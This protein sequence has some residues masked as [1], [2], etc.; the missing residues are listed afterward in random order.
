VAAQPGAETSP[1]RLAGVGGRPETHRPVSRLVFLALMD[2]FVMDVYGIAEDAEREA[3]AWLAAEARARKV[4]GAIVVPNLDGISQL[5]GAL[6]RDQAHL[7]KKNRYLDQDGARIEVYTDQNRPG[8]FKGPVFVP[9]ANE[10]SVERVEEMRPVAI[11]AIPW[12]EDDLSD[13]KRAHDPVDLRTGVRAGAQPA[14]L[15]PLVRAALISLTAPEPHSSGIHHPSDKAR[16]TRTFRALYLCGEPLDETEIRTWAIARGWQPRHATTLGELA[17]K[18]AAGRTVRG[19]SMTKTEAKEIVG[20]LR[21][22]TE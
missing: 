12:G 17:G 21:A 6:G 22:L 13:W 9:W 20:R 5:S 8:T 3:I 10:A 14:E 1:N 15:A 19:A 18:V 4:P 2:R 16:A 7:L 11:C